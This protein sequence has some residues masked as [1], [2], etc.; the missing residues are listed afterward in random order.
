LGS[1]AG[2]VRGLPVLVAFLLLQGCAPPAQRADAMAAGHGWTR[3]LV[4]GTDF[5]HVVYA[6]G[7]SDPARPLHVYLEGDGSP[8][9]DPWTPAPD[10]TPRRPVMLPLMALDASPSVY[11]GRPCYFGLAR[12][13]PCTPND[14]TLGRF[15]E[16]VVES[17][18]Q[19]IEQLRRERGGGQVEIYGHSGGGALAVLLAARLP[20]VL[21]VVTLAGNLDPDAWA[22]HHGYS[23]LTGS[24]NPSR[25]GA[26]PASVVQLHIAGAEDATV[27]PWMVDRASRQL[28]A[29]T[30]EV[31]PNVT[32]S[33]CWRER[34]GALMEAAAGTRL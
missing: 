24:L 27:P 5:R 34:W 25:R 30:I 10:P 26:L 16:R 3:T 13:P 9:V 18:A 33:C 8:Y 32:H 22:K 12:D 1:L 15:S 4:R 21:R 28:G 14:W 31:L 19:A 7:I 29:A 20:G 23:L 17:L 2:A 6:N 11:V